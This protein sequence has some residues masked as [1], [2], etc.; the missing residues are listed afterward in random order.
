MKVYEAVANGFIKEGTDTVFGLLGDGQLTW[1]DAMAKHPGMRIVDAREEGASLAMADGWARAT[2]RVGVC[3]VTQ[4][5]GL[6]RTMA[7]LITTSRS[8]TPLVIYTSRTSFNDDTSNQYIDQ[9]R[10]V[11]ATGAGYI[12]VV[13]PAYA[14]ESVRQAFYRAKTER[15]PI[16]LCLPL[17]IQDKECE[18]DGDDYVTSSQLFGG[19]QKVCPEPARIKQAVEIIAASRK[20]VLLIGRG[21]MNPEALAAAGRLAKRMGA[22]ITTS[23]IAKGSLAE[24]E[25]YTGVSGAFS[26]RTAMQLF[27]E[28]D[29]LIAAG[30]GLNARTLEGGYLYPN[31]RVVHIDIAEHV[32]MGTGRSADCYVQGDAAYTLAEIDAQLE[33]RGVG[34]EGYHTTAV[35]KALLD[36]DRDPG[37]FE[38][39][40]GT[41]DP[42]AAVRLMDEKLPLDI[43]IVNGTGHCFTMFNWGIK[44]PRS[45]HVFVT[46]FGCIG[47]AMATSIGVSVGFGKPVV[48]VEGDGAAMQ[49]IQ[50]LDTASRIGAKIL[51]VIMNDQAYGAEFHRLKAKGLNADLSAMRSPEFEQVGRAFGCR[52][53]T[54]RTL[55]ELASAIEAFLKGDGPMVLDLRIS[56]NVVS[57]PYR[58]VHFAQDV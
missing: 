43:G 24:S 14:E 49:N 1:W 54:A 16:V 5:P 3:S 51:F 37:E 15:R 26:T 55:E 18:S 41:M 48:Y 6:A 36:A 29:C 44:R 35:R 22:L 23:L 28:A 52:G 17:D 53:A 56:R 9:D 34:N 38:I 31:A 2:G 25:Y 42:R 45:L 7:S 39:E 30:A 46:A 4:G 40:P 21:A 27:E 20:P 11:S 50:E 13:T 32:L 57:I 58:R 47:Q 33:A 12:E 8:R 19:Q 10:L